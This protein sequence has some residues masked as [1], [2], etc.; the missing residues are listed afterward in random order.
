MNININY[1][2]NWIRIILKIKL[3]LFI[4]VVAFSASCVSI[5]I[6]KD[7]SL[8]MQYYILQQTFKWLNPEIYQIITKEVNKHRTSI[9]IN[10]DYKKLMCSVIQAESGEYCKNNYEYMKRVKSCAGA[11]GIMQIMKV[12][13]PKNPDARYNPNINVKLGVMYFTYCLQKSIKEGYKNPIRI[14]CAYYNAGAGVKLSRYKNW[15]YAN[16]IQRYYGKA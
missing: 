15:G 6:T 14:A 10:V 11:I 13:S 3:I 1:Y 9:S 2:K 5:K 12:H 16:K 8:D 4:S 7:N